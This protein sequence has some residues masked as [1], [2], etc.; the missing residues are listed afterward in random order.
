MWSCS[1][2]GKTGLTYQEALESE[3]KARKQLASFP[4]YLQKPILYLTT[5]THRGRMNEL[6]DDVF[7]YCKDRFFIGEV[8]DVAV[9]N[10]RYVYFNYYIIY[11]CI[12][13]IR[14]TYHML[15]SFLFLD[16]TR[17]NN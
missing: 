6:N 3:E 7:V 11:V 14:N 16:R 9:R 17:V 12:Q 1:L 2:T 10:E 15:L 5:L 8:V 4:D 13:F